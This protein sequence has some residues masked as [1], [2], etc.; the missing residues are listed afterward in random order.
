[1]SQRSKWSPLTA[2]V[3]VTA[4]VFAT[5]GGPTSPSP[6]TPGATATPT[7]P[8]SEAPFDGLVYPADGSSACDIDGYQGVMG[9]ITAVDAQT[10]EF[11]LCRPDVA[12]LSKIA[13][14][15]LGIQDAGYLEETRGGGDLLRNP[16][17]TGP[18]KLKANGWT[19]GAEI[20]LE[21]YD[22][23]WGTKP[24]TPEA[25][26][27][28]GDEAAQ[29]L[30]ELTSAN[31]DGI[32][33]V[34][35]DDFPA[36]E[37]NV[38][39][40]LY[41]RTA[42]NVLYLGMN[43]TKP[44][45][46]NEKVRQAIAMGI[47]RERIIDTFFPPGSVVASHFTPCEIPGGC[48][49]DDWYDFDPAAARDLLAEAGYPDGFSTKL[50]LRDPVQ[51]YFPT[52]PDIAT[53]V[54]AQLLQ[55]LNIRAEIDVIDETTYLG[56]ASRGELEGLFFL[57]WCAD[58]PD[59]TNFLDTFFGVGADESFGTK[60]DDITGPLLEGAQTADPAARAAAY[61]EANNAI[62]QHVPM[63]PISHGG[64]ATAFRADV[65]GAHSS[66]LNSE[67]LFAMK[68]GD[69]G[70]LV[71]M[72]NAE[73]G[74]IYCADETDGEALRVCEQI[75]E[76]LYKYKIGGTEPEPSLAESCTASADL[77]T[78]TC[79]LRQGVT[80]HNGSTFDANDVVT[81]YAVQW[82][83]EHPLHVGRE[84]LFEYWGYLFG[85]GLNPAPAS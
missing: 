58:F 29:R 46:D 60:W 54:Q 15:S 40:E 17:G 20:A 25:V 84:G 73:P 61:E 26:V 11:H 3:A 35:T 65:E 68:A 37:A 43:N 56:I 59:V 55:N 14:A 48:E 66:P 10:V 8:A 82:D 36:V 81:T 62:R 50:H 38:E 67:A 80:F 52:P 77:M 16:I 78:W 51:C 70:Q 18:Y 74:G 9:Q 5:C 27:R 57:G 2:L 47:D 44:Y 22:G 76:S 41:P 12:F 32:D 23:Y 85:P 6:R 69:R 72:Q 83:A 28:W 71:F 42:L 49:G 30:V 53:D 34:G 1:M 13:F 19:S 33:N 39:L 75:F 21:T 45:S 31:V 24:L 63:V 7:A 4:I 79:E 64:S